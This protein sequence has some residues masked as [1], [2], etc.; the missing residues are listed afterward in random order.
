MQKLRGYPTETSEYWFNATAG[1][2]LPDHTLPVAY[3]F[4]RYKSYTETHFAE[5]MASTCRAPP[6]V[7]IPQC[8]YWKHS[9]SNT[10]LLPQCLSHIGHPIELPR[11]TWFEL[12]FLSHLHSCL[13]WVGVLRDLR[14]GCRVITWRR[15]GNDKNMNLFLDMHEFGIKI[16]RVLW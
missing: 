15:W 5:K 2:L 6:T 16:R 9:A 7:W 14:H 11:W 1:L 13:I 8:Q 10:M 4:M 12:G 3:K